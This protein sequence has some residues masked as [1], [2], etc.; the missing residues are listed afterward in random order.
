MIKCSNQTVISLKL[1]DDYMRIELA[2]ERKTK[3]KF[4]SLMI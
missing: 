2:I 1:N 3:T 4:N